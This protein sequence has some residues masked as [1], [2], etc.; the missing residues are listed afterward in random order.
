MPTH[1]VRQGECLSSIA[2]QYGYAHYDELYQHPGNARL[3]ELRPNPHLLYPG[4]EIFIPEREPPAFPVATGERATFRVQSP[5]AVLRIVLQDADGR[6]QVGVPWKL[7]VGEAVHRGETSD[8][9]LVEAEVP[10]HTTE[11]TLEVE[12]KID[13]DPVTHRYP[14]QIG[15][16]DPVDTTTGVKARLTNLGFACGSVKDEEDERTTE[17]IAAF[18]QQAGVD[19]EGP[20]GE[21]TR[22]ALVERYGC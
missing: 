15:G 21:R 20:C 9:G 22:A 5:M 14:L 12:M 4:D 18:R 7:E 19:E 13:D 17:A 8:D 3:R 6:A 1:V 11:A 16:L 2:A 10:A